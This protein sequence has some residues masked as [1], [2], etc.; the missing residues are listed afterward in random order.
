MSLLRSS[1][2][3]QDA[4]QQPAPEPLPEAGTPSPAAGG[5]ASGGSSAA[6]AVSGGAGAASHSR[7]SPIEQR[8]GTS[9]GIGTAQSPSPQRPRGHVNVPPLTGLANLARQ[10][11]AGLANLATA[12]LANSVG[13]PASTPLPPS[14]PP[15]DIPSSSTSAR[16][17][18]SSSRTSGRLA[19]SATASSSARLRMPMRSGSSTSLSGARSPSPK[20]ARSASA[21]M[22]HGSASLAH[23]SGSLSPERRPRLVRG[24]PGAA[25]QP[26]MAGVA[27]HTA[28][29]SSRSGTSF[30]LSVS[31]PRDLNF[32]GS[33]RSGSPSHA[34]V[35]PLPLG[36]GHQ[37]ASVARSGGGTPG[38]S[39]GMRVPL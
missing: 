33:A 13:V 21:A 30:Q 10:D 22:V 8:S 11:F 16:S 38:R 35:P 23:H 36:G 14:A 34:V 15:P 3:P 9:P 24:Q 17:A 1:S 37:A 29:G 32:P 25:S 19:A 20:L 26:S 12:N 27:R 28:Q 18:Q 4:D 7:G 31:R 39:R 6:G 5:A 2:G